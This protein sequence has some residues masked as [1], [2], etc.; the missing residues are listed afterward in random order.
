MLLRSRVAALAAMVLLA[1]SPASVVLAGGEWPQGPN[2]NEAFFKI[3][4]GRTMT[5]IR[6]GMENLGSAAGL[7]TL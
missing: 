1:L 7:P 6:T 3:F 2:Y 5:C 4:S